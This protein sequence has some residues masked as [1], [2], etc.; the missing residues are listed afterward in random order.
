MERTYHPDYD[1]LEVR[2]S[3]TR[4]LQHEGMR[5]SNGGTGGS[6]PL[7]NL[8]V[9]CMVEANSYVF[10]RVRGGAYRRLTRT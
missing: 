8:A 10:L 3:M 2:M 9:I 4:S 5:T 7:R 6:R 1:Q